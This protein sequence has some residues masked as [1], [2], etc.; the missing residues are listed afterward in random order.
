MKYEKTPIKPTKP[1]LAKSKG[2]L[3]MTRDMDKLSSPL[4]A[5]YLFKRHYMSLL[6]LATGMIMGLSI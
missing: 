1:L 5:L 2:A 6:L 4:I 3:S